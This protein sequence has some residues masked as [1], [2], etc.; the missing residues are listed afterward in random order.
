MEPHHL[1]NALDSEG[2]ASPEPPFLPNLVDLFAGNREPRADI[3]RRD[4]QLSAKDVH[5]HDRDGDGGCD[6]ADGGGTES[7]A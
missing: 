1:G 4:P 2:S 7:N 3:P 5:N 6:Q